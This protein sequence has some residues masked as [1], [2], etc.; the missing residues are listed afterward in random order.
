MPNLTYNQ[1]KQKVAALEAKHK[2]V[3][4]LLREIVTETGMGSTEY[5]T[6]A[7]YLQLSDTPTDVPETEG[8]LSWNATR[9]T[10]NMQ[11]HIQGTV[12]QVGQEEWV[13]VKNTTGDLLTD[14]TVVVASSVSGEVLTLAEAQATPG[15][16]ARTAGIL[17]SD[18]ADGEFGFAT[19]RGEV[20]G[21]NTSMFTPFDNLYVS[22]T[23][24]GTLTNERPIP[25]DYTIPM[26]Y[27][28]NSQ[29]DGLIY[30][31]SGNPSTGILGTDSS[32]ATGDPTGWIDNEDITV[33][34]DST[35][36]TITLIGTLKY[37]WRGQIIEVTSPWVSDPHPEG[38][39]EA[40]FLYTTDGSTFIWATSPWE[41]SDLQV[42]F[43]RHGTSDKYALR[44]VHGLM[45][46]QA[47]EE[48]HAAIGTY[49]LSGGDL[50]GH[51]LTSVTAA[52]RRPDVAVMTIKDEDIRTPNPALTSSL[53]SQFG[54][55]STATSVVTTGAA[56]IVPVLAA[57]PYYNQFSSPNWVQTLMAN[58]TYMSVWLVGIPA[59]ADA[60]SQAYRYLWMQG[61]TNGT[62]AGQQALFPAD[63][64]L[65]ALALQATEFIF[66]AQVI[67]RYTAGDW[68]LVDVI[69][70]LGNRQ[71]TIGAPGGAFLSTV[72][73]DDTL[74][75]LGTA[76]SPLSLLDI[77]GVGFVTNATTPPVSTP[78]GGGYF[79]VE[80][81]ALK[82]KGSSGTVTTL[83]VA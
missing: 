68:H 58:N 82:Y 66:S 80:A 22:A 41:F 32:V 60:E 20:H 15:P 75:G 47:H 69:N 67:I 18:V 30:I 72:T 43:V 42:A 16:F 10:L 57:N 40:Y 14:G 2:G 35:A 52:D 3:E 51:T 12:L 54:L 36:R 56:E 73:S 6:R 70:L 38:L 46:W 19:V 63:L 13:Y 61:Q 79:Y 74:N 26:G 55:T 62:L 23:V 31:N 71:A 39:D 76:A 65:G 4:E 45:P 11:S 83:G 49:R 37:M 25:P 21:F 34:Y 8:T 27:A 48:F 28:L 29:V 17:T 59:T 7:K 44:E 33:T 81:G 5:P 78:T 50:S 24:A 9:N 77:D 53:Y 64:N 1:L